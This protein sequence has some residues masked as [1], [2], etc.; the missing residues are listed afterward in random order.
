MFGEYD[1]VEMDE[2]V[3]KEMER[4]APWTEYEDKQPAATPRS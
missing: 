2:G 4:Q 3:R 1:D